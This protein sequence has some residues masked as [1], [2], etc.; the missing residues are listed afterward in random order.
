MPIV[1]NP[2]KLDDEKNAMVFKMILNYEVFQNC[3]LLPCC[4]ELTPQISGI[5]CPVFVEIVKIS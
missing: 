1:P 3:D 4:P 2:N 5:D